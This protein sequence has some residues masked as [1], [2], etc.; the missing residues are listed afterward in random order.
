MQGDTVHSLK[1]KKVQ[2][3]I[4]RKF[5]FDWLLRYPFIEPI[6]PTNEN[7]T[8]QEVKFISCSWKLGKVVKLQ[9]KLDTIKK[10][11]GKVYDKKTVNDE[12]KSTYRWKYVSECRNLQFKVEYN[13]FLLNKKKREESG[14]TIKSHFGKMMETHFLSKTI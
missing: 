11:V 5:K 3:D 1:R 10:H 12:N 6:S 13:E 14:G 9:R 7:D 8:S 2:W 4:G